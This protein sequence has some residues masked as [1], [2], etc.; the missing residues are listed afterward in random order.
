MKVD[1]IG[2]GAM[3]LHCALALPSA[4]QVTL[5]H[6]DFETGVLDIA[7]DTGRRRQ[8]T[9]RPLADRAPIDAA[10]VTTKAG[11]AE[12]AVVACLPALEPDAE[13]L[14]LHNGLGPQ[15]RIGAALDARQRLYVGVT[16]EGAL[17]ESPTR[18]RHTG[19]G[20]TL[21]GPWTT[22][23]LPGPLVRQLQ[24]S[25]LRLQWEPEPLQ[26]RQAVWRKLIVNCAINPLT[27]LHNVPNGALLEDRFRAQ[28]QAL[29]RLACQVAVA[30][31]ILLDSDQMQQQ[32]ESV[33]HGTARN[34][35][36]MQQ[37]VAHG[38]ATEAP[39]ILGEL[40]RRGTD[41]GLDMTPLSDLAGRLDRLCLA[42]GPT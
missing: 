24:H 14:L 19:R 23:L 20:S 8:V 31:G 7:D 16:T 42:N 38:R 37:D 36:S 1:V 33:L 39:E 21:A 12:A 9:T 27:A 40:I 22:D 3:G 10:L 25:S 41:H 17:R 18:V 5:R 32:V 4:V 15:D 26:V 28:W 35:S 11:R 2:P 29:T 34:F 30:E 13:I 6:P